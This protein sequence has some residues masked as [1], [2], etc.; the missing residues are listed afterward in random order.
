MVSSNYSQDNNE[1]LLAQLKALESSDKNFESLEGDIDSTRG[2]VTDQN[3]SIDSTRGEVVD[4]NI[5]LQTDQS[6]LQT[7]QSRLSVVEADIKDKVTT[8]QEILS[9]FKNT[10]ISSPQDQTP[11]L[12]PSVARGEVP[13]SARPA[14]INVSPDHAEIIEL[15]MNRTLIGL[16]TIPSQNL[17]HF[18]DASGVTLEEIPTE[19]LFIKDDL[20]AVLN[21]STGMCGSLEG[22]SL[23][24][25]NIRNRKRNRAFKFNV[26]RKDGT[27]VPNVSI[28]KT[29][30]KDLIRVIGN[31][32]LAHRIIL[33]KKVENKETVKKEETQPI[34]NH[35][36][37]EQSTSEERQ[38]IGILRK[39]QNLWFAF[40]SLVRGPAKA[41]VS[42]SYANE[43]KKNEAKRNTQ[44]VMQDFQKAQEIKTRAIEKKTAEMRL[45]YDIRIAEHNDM[46]S[47]Q[48]NSHKPHTQKPLGQSHKVTK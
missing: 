4:K 29:I 1:E 33:I 28:Q 2:E 24:K 35:E 37:I 34:Q 38:D 23:S 20:V 6:S 22:T 43:V 45:Q 21:P 25:A 18:N 26:R 11:I 17:D 32:Y 40:M 47:I 10:R 3:L 16:R 27:I 44:R 7:D 46:P 15:L 8:A 5:T 30:S 14:T 39:L 12:S 36:V 13:A 19:E 9:L 31:A 42:E 48:P 41:E